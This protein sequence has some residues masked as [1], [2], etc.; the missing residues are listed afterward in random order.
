VPHPDVFDKLVS[1][2]KRRGF[3]FQSSEIYGGAGSVW[4]YGP[5]GVELKRNI[6]DRW[7]N[8]LVRARDDIEGLDAAILMHPRVWEA[9]GHVAGFTDPLV[10]CRNCKKRFRADDPK[11]K[12]KPGS[13]DAQCPACGMKGTMSEPRL[14]NLM[15]KTF[16]GPVED[17]AS[18]VYL[19]P[20]TAQGI[21][22]N[23]LNVQQST[24]QK[25]PF[26]IAQIG[27]A[28]RNEITPGNFI[29]R[30]REFEQMEMQFF[31]DPAAAPPDR[32]DMQWFEYWKA[33]RMDWHRD[34]GL[35]SARLQFHQ[36][37]KEE[38]A[39]YARAAFDIQFDFGGTLGFQEIE[40]VHH[41]GDFDLGR[42]QEYSGKKLEYIDQVS[43]RRY[44]PYVI[45]T[46]VGADRTTL[47]VLVNAYKE[48]EVPGEQEG[49]TVLAVHP[50]LAPIK[51]GIFPLVK[52]D[53]MPEFAAK[54]ADE[55]RRSFPVF[56]DESG[57]IGRRYRRMDEVGTPFAVTVDGQTTQDSTVTV[58]DRDTLKQDRIAA[59]RVTDWIRQRLQ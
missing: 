31:V 42:H 57:A 16:M 33:Q 3:I 14:F 56:Y 1:L 29:F 53:G 34:L 40:G 11:I 22:V 44:L 35:D 46:S 15:F 10:D 47:A 39:H 23:F 43:N 26:G 24:R 20:E 19:R 45:E 30:T 49:R 8:A 37:S 48:E 13:P 58:R 6:K 32:S 36:H 7:W 4:D 5:L 9:S 55:L 50:S 17:S 12:G 38:L 18:V 25:V 54:L 52:K 21:Y 41:R 59:D 28:F 51:T 27:K 2:C